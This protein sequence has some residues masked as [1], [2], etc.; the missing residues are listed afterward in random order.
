MALKDR[1]SL[2][3]RRKAFTIFMLLSASSTAENIVE[4]RDWILREYF[5]IF[6]PRYPIESVKAGRTKRL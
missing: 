4:R 3:S 1:Y 6:L 2:S 5:L